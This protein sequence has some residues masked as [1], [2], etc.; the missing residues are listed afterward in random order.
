MKPDNPRDGKASERNVIPPTVGVILAGGLARRM[1]G[2][3]KALRLIGGKPILSHVIDRLAP[4]C[5]ALV[6][7][8]NG[9]SERFVEFGLPVVADGVPDFAGPLAGVLAALEWSVERYPSCLWVVSVAADTPFI[10]TDLVERLHRARNEGNFPLAVA[11][12]GERT[13]PV[14]ALWPV[15]IKEDLRDALKNEGLR[16]DGQWM[17]RYR[18]AYADWPMS[19]YDPFFNINTPDDFDMA[20]R[21]IETIRKKS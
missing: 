7:S 8:A 15:G 3:D 5:S 1:G 12:S 6:I 17:E 2:G 13:H 20:D 16:K 19:P 4:Q 14:D 21:L 10:P 11:R 9:P 18:V